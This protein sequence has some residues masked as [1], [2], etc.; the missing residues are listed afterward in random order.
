[1]PDIEDYLADADKERRK[2]G[3]DSAEFSPELPKV[4]HGPS[5]IRR[6]GAGMNFGNVGPLHQRIPRGA[7]DAPGSLGG[8][9]SVTGV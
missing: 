8:D 3:L 4:V 6:D 9:R 7:E 5:G 1:M 2:Y